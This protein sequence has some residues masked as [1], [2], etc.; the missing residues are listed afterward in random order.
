MEDVP[1]GTILSTTPIESA[2]EFEVKTTIHPLVKE[3]PHDMHLCLGLQWGGVHLNENK[4]TSE[5]NWILD[6]TGILA[7]NTKPGSLRILGRIEFL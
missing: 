3:L 2:K 7:H 6:G 1:R 4:I 5:K